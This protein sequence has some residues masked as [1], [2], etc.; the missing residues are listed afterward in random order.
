MII[1]IHAHIGIVPGEY[2]MRVENQLAGMQKYHIDYALV[3]DIACGES[4]TKPKE[5]FAYQT[6]INEK[7]AQTVREHSDKLGLLLWC[8]P[9]AE[10][11]FNQAFENLYL[12]NRDIV[13]GL[14][15]HPDISGLAFNDPRL[16]P[17][18]EMAKTYDLPVLIHTKETPYSKVRFVCEM[19]SHY[20]SVNFILGH[21]S[22]ADDKTEA[23][24]AL[25]DYPNIY[26]DTAWVYYKDAVEA[27]AQGLE[28]KILFGTDSPINGEDTYAEPDF[29]PAYYNNAL[30]PKE[31]ADKI[32]F[33]NAQRLFN[34]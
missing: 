14:K 25:R 16:Y 15:V 3:S 2:D 19:A 26:G 31:T 8:R 20:R 5:G 1:D 27:C 28:D 17:Y 11:G 6:L 32:M 18:L 30:L 13:K 4:K 10:Q 21:M 12:Q 9:N 22:L 24:R 29:Y 34:L 7:A 33:K 23:F